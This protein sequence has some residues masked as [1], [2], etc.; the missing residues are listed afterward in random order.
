MNTYLEYFGFCFKKSSTH[1]S[2]TMM[3]REMEMLMPLFITNSG[4]EYRFMRHTVLE[5]NT[6]RKKTGKAASLCFDNLRA[7]YGLDQA[8]PLFRILCTLY[9]HEPESLRQL[10]FL[11]ALVRD[12]VLAACTPSILKLPQNHEIGPDRIYDLI[13][14]HF[15][16][17]YRESTTKS[18]SRNL[19]SSWTQAGL[20]AKQ[21]NTLRIRQ[22]TRP[23]VAGVA[24][25][26]LLAH[27]TGQRGLNMFFSNY[28]RLLDC[29]EKQALELAYQASS[30]GLISFKRI[31]DVVEVQFPRLLTEKESKLIYEQN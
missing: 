12:P 4:M 28:V 7:L 15:P 9:I 13:L 3:C 8:V 23:T 2:R 25:A 17:R 10:L 19:L 24:Y 21:T 20:V 16:D 14:Q 27:V 31:G 11:L 1:A 29:N 30:K 18:I 26:L 6:L 22:H 5:N